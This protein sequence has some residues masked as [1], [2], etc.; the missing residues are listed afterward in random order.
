MEKETYLL[1]DFN[2]DRWKGIDMKS[3]EKSIVKLNKKINGGFILGEVKQHQTI[4]EDIDVSLSNASHSIKNIH[5]ENNK[6]FGDVVFLPNGNGKLAEQ[7]IKEDFCQ[8]GIRAIRVIRAVGIEEKDK[9]EI[10]D[11][12]TWDVVESTYTEKE[13]RRMKLEQLKKS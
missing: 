8:F 13:K 10:S 11:I 3:V 12:I 5:I 1:T 9:I 2:R 6:I 7:K 4:G